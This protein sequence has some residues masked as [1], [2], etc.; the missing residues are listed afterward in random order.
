MVPVSSAVSGMIFER[1]PPLMVPTVITTG[2]V[3][4]FICLLT[5]C[6]NPSIIC[7]ADAMGSTPPQGCDPWLPLPFILMVNQSEDAIN[8]PSL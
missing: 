1:T 3:I 2:A 7:A 4:K 5:I 6:C 8:A